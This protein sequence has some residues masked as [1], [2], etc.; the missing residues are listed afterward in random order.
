MRKKKQIKSVFPSGGI[1]EL[2]ILMR[3]CIR[4]TTKRKEKDV[5]AL[6]RIDPKYIQTRIDDIPKIVFFSPYSSLASVRMSE[7]K[8]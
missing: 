4:V 7:P 8:L 1:P 5:S 6:Q 3:T 2:G